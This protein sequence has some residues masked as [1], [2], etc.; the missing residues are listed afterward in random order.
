MFMTVTEMDLKAIGAR[1]KSRRT[2]LEI[3]QGELAEKVFTSRPNI[4]RYERGDID[5]NITMIGRLAK[6]LN[7]SPS[8]LIGEDEFDAQ[9]DEPT[10]E[11]YYRGLP[12]DKQSMFLAMIKA[13]HDQVKRDE[14]THGRKAETDSELDPDEE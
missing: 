8:W 6:A 13:A 14:T 9:S 7:V 1:I 10:V 4:A 5:F 2:Y 11:A 12:P 3:T